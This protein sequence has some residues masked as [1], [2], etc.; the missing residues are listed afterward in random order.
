MAKNEKFVEVLIRAVVKYDSELFK[1]TQIERKVA[2]CFN[3]ENEG[4]NELEIVDY[5]ATESWDV[6]DE[7]KRK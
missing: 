5:R 2:V 3:G 7:Y 1:E 6:T 4:D